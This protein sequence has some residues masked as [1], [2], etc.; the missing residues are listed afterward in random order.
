MT[1]ISSFCP[2]ACDIET[3]WNAFHNH[4]KGSMSNMIAPHDNVVDQIF[5]AM[6]SFIVTMLIDVLMMVFY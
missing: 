5:Q 6:V 4:D 2:L 1:S 3:S